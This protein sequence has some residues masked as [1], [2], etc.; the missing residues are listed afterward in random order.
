MTPPHEGTARQSMPAAKSAASPF[1][2]GLLG[3]WKSCLP[4]VDASYSSLDAVVWSTARALQ[5]RGVSV[6]VACATATAPAASG[7]AVVGVSGGLDPLLRGLALR[8]R[9]RWSSRRH[10]PGYLLRG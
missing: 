9:T 2:I 5:R 6:T 1:H 10:H 8:T 4:G 3:S 7:I